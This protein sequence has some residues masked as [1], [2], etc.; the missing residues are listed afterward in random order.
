MLFAICIVH[1]DMA[2]TNGGFEDGIGGWNLVVNN[3]G[4]ATI[5]TEAHSG[6]KALRIVT[7]PTRSSVYLYQSLSPLP[8]S[9]NLSVWL[10]F[11]KGGQEIALSNGWIPERGPR[12]ALRL[13]VLPGTPQWEIQL[14]G[15]GQTVFG[16]WVYWGIEKDRWYNFKIVSD[17]FEKKRTLYIDGEKALEVGIVN[18]IIPDTIWIGYCGK[19]H[20]EPDYHPPTYK[21]GGSSVIWDDVSVTSYVNPDF[22]DLVQIVSQLQQRV[23]ELDALYQQML[24]E[25]SAFNTSLVNL[26]DDVTALQQEIS[27]MDQSLADVE[28]DIERLWSDAANPRTQ[29]E[30]LSQKVNQIQTRLS[31]MEA[32]LLS[33]ATQTLQEIQ[34]V[35]STLSDMLRDLKDNTTAQLTH[36][37][38]QVDLVKDDMATLEAEVSR[39]FNESSLSIDRTQR[40]VNLIGNLTTAQI[41]RLSSDLSSNCSSLANLITTINQSLA[42][43][44]ETQGSLLSQDVKDNR[45]TMERRFTFLN[46]TISDRHRSTMAQIQD[47]KDQAAESEKRLRILLL[48]S[49]SLAATGVVLTAAL[50]IYR[51][52]NG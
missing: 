15:G 3:A 10:R 6:L 40:L 50:I 7:S 2:V 19:E 35:E 46:V 37:E 27:L 32:N 24:S 23:L 51:K 29:L 38:D 26:I 30:A 5:S 48:I 39:G 52:R 17:D 8:K 25:V 44:I 21:L 36:L 45:D 20:D 13:I 28:D 31:A 42:N 18:S 14:Q 11:E 4:S 1:A 41:D 34:A 9:Y 22:E 12:L 16:K 43:E 33:F 49:I 47:L